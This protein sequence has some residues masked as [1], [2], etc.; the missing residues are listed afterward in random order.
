MPFFLSG[1]AVANARNLS[2]LC[3]LRTLLIAVLLAG[4]LLAE[5]VHGIPLL[6]DGAIVLA[7]ALLAV[8]NA[9]TL[10]RLKRGGEVSE[11]VLFGQ[12]LVDVL[13]VTLVLYRTGG[14]TNPFISWYLV[15]LAIAA[16]TLRLGFTI[17]L[18]LLTLSTYSLLLY[19]YVPFAPFGGMQA[20][21]AVTL[22]A[23]DPHLHHTMTLQSHDH[24]A[25][26][27]F[28]LH[29][30]GMWL[31]FVLSAALITFFVT[32]MSHALREQDRLLAEQHER[33]LQR[34]QVV[35]LG[36]LAAGV[37]HSL[38]TPLST[39]A[40]IAREIENSIA[41]DSPLREEVATLRRQLA[42][43]RNILGDLR[44]DAEA[45][46]ARQSLSRF[47]H[48]LTERMEVLH[49]GLQFFLEMNAPDC[50][51][52]P[53]ALLSQVLTSLLDN[54][55]QAAHSMVRFS[56]RH[57]GEHCVMDICDDGPGIAPEVLARLGQPF[58]SSKHEGLGLGYFL[59]HASVNQMGGHIR[60]QQQVGGGTHT[61]LQLPWSVICR[62]EVC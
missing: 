42:L 32:R 57:D 12:L 31:S 47:L 44:S 53:P 18:A 24:E 14:A 1:E 5:L 52:R 34:E 40:V 21:Q 9:W 17:V 58:V 16:A 22:M 29:V 25:G 19:H 35:S 37:A 51:I 50:D 61:E 36:A 30:F 4:V 39:M 60:V 62:E 38:G 7:I 13:L 11:E 28:N 6:H 49:P 27:G 48:Q 55:A 3:L 33:L 45:Q 43:C 2:R 20:G 8:F 54:A 56:L 10:W 59:S 41:D 23:D 15:P 26:R 46:E